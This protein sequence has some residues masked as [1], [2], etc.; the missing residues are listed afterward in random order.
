MIVH[1]DAALSVHKVC[2]VC[3]INFN[4]LA[5]KYVERVLRRNRHIRLI[6]AHLDSAFWNTKVARTSVFLVDVADSYKSIDRCLRLLGTWT[7]EARIVAIGSMSTPEELCGLLRLGIHGFVT[8][9]QVEEQL[10]AAIASVTSGRLWVEHS[11]LEEAARHL[12]QGDKSDT[13]RVLTQRQKQVATLLG[14]K[15]SNKEIAYSLGIKERTV[16]F[17]LSRIFG[18]LG[19]QDRHSA[20]E[21]LAVPQ[22][23]AK[24]GIRGA[25]DGPL[26]AQAVHPDTESRLHRALQS[27][28]QQTRDRV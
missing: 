7:R 28:A 19:V 12:S 3:L 16:K 14:R 5:Y 9:S 18:K 27:V 23:A 17:H 25:I 15:M 11:V 1:E 2:T 6:Q 26:Q 22:I 20:V 4:A 21:Y 24:V 13:S 8:Y 10:A